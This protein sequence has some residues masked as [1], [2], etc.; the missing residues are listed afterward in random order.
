MHT[1]LEKL[2]APVAGSVVVLITVPQAVQVTVSEPSA[3]Q[4]G[5]T[6]EVEV[7]ECGHSV[8]AGGVELLAGGVELPAVELLAGGVLEPP[9]GV[10]ELAAVPVHLLGSFLHTGQS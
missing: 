3:P 2:W 4:V 1:P 6:R 9:E 7:L 10:L 8:G 5:S